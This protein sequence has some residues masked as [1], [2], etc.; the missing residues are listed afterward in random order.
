MKKGFQLKP[1]RIFSLELR[2]QIVGQIE[3]RELTVIEAV[4][5][6][7]IGGKQ[8]VYNWLYKYSATLKKGTRMVMEKD[9][10]ENKSQELR[11]RI[12]ELEAALGR[13]S[14]EADLYRIIVE[15]ASDEYRV[16]LKKSFGDQVSKSQKK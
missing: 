9:S 7:E 16:D 11:S 8:T 14:L 4:R 5:E 3:R 13:K 2:K 1:Q 10:Q 15:K 12:K 6:Y